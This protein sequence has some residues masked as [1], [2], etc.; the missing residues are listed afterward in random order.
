MDRYSNGRLNGFVRIGLIAASL[1][2]GL[3]AFI[4]LQIVI[5]RPVQAHSSTSIHA[6]SDFTVSLSADQGLK[7]TVNGQGA[8]VTLPDIQQAVQAVTT[9]AYFTNEGN[10][11][12]LSNANLIINGGVTLSLTDDTVSWLKLRSNA[13]VSNT[14]A[15]TSVIDYGSF[16]YLKTVSGTIIIKNTR[17]TS[18][19]TLSNTYDT[20]IGNGRSYVIAQYAARMDIINSDMSYLGSSDGSSYGV[21]WKDGAGPGVNQDTRVTGNILSSTF[22]YN[23]YGIYTFQASN[24]IFRY[25]KFHDNI[26]YG[27]DPH[28]LTHDVVVEDNES[29]NNGDHGFII[30]RGCYNFVFRRN[31]SYNNINT[32]SGKYHSGGNAQGF[33]IDQG[34][35][36]ALHAFPQ[37]PSHDNLLDNN[38]AWGNS[39]YGLR[40][41]GGNMNIVQNNVFTSNLQGITIEDIN[42]YSN[43]IIANLIYSNTSSGVVIDTNAH[44]NMIMQNSIYENGANGV[45]VKYGTGNQILKNTLNRNAAYGIRA[46]QTTTTTTHLNRW[47]QN[48]SFDNG[49][50][51]VGVIAGANDGITVPNHILLAQGLLTGITLPGSTVEFFGDTKGQCRNYMGSITADSTGF[52]TWT[53]TVKG[54]YFVAIATAING[55]SSS[56]S[57]PVGSFNVYVPV[58]LR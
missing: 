11:V 55:N 56:T 31:K 53:P 28:D 15:L 29:Y 16:V 25:N 24:M 54:M 30:S 18:W 8:K 36:S 57:K 27:F 44:D 39:G 22:S 1:A 12:W 6:P 2:F 40:I 3:C 37:I 38:Q 51:C 46:V 47:S 4:G 49:T 45:Y 32:Y 7:V 43:T 17:V 5:S 42:S 50:G 10:G 26:G 23:L 13:S 33:M 41:Q 9:T 19:D 20:D 52:F 58:A 34:S 35:S 21:V 14:G 48:L